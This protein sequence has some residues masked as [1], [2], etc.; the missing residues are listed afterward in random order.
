MDN[1]AGVVGAWALGSR[2]TE[3]GLGTAGGGGSGDG[4]S[5][6]GDTQRG[7]PRGDQGRGIGLWATL[8]VP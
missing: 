7:R 2:G 8:E 1:A 5:G 6:G 4:R 3:E